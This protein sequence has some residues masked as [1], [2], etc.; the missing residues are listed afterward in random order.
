MHAG[1]PLKSQLFNCPNDTRER[2]EGAARDRFS[3]QGLDTGVSPCP[4]PHLKGNLSVIK[5]SMS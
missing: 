1:I 4:S 5:K 2:E 3:I